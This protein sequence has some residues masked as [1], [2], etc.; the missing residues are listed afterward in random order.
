MRSDVTGGGGGGTYG[1][2][3]YLKNVTIEGGTLTAELVVNPGVL[4]DGVDI[5]VLAADLAAHIA[6]PVDAHDASAI[7]VT[8]ASLSSGATDVQAALVALDAGTLAL[9]TVALA[10]NTAN[11]TVFSVAAATNTAIQ[12]TYSVVRSAANIECGTIYVV[13]DGVNATAAVVGANLG[14]LGVTFDAVVSA[15]NVILRASTSS[16]GTAA[17]LKYRK[18]AWAA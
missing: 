16:T 1:S 17:Q 14:T 12:V 3:Q 6:N 18:Q 11:Q 13:N 4:I 5:S 10:D 2:P 8:P 9:T 15:G 7:S